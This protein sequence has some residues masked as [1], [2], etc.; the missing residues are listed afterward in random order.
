MGIGF[1]F[2]NF[3]LHLSHIL[4]FPGSTSDREPGNAGDTRQVP[5]LAQED[6][7]EEGTATH[8]TILAWR[9]PQTE[10]PSR[11]QSTGSKRVGRNWRD[12]ARMHEAS[13]SSLTRE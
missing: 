9:I 4:G 10:E 7:L 11:L 13:L 5:S 2:F 8:S 6:A 1:F 12:L 3:L